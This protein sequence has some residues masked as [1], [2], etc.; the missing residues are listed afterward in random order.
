MTGPKLMTGFPARGRLLGLAVLAAAILSS[1]APAPKPLPAP[2]PAPP[3]IEAPAQ[4][5]E[6]PPEKPET[7]PPAKAEPAAPAQPEELQPVKEVVVRGTATWTDTGLDVG[8]GE[9]LVIRATG[10]ISLQRGNPTAFCG[11]EG[12]DLKSAQ[13]PLPDRNIGSLVGRVVQLVSVETDPETK[14]EIRNELIEVFYVGAEARVRMPLT[15]RLFLGINENV[16]GDNSGEFK[17]WIFRP[18]EE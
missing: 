9:E 16:A 8:E 5:V 1:C 15:G 6:V 7:V 4:P 3:P 13:Q 17:A 14:K 18:R 11:P 10:W 12:Y 2:P